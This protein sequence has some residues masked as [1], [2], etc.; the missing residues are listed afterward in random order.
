MQ[1]SVCG[2]WAGVWLWLAC[3][4]GALAQPLDLFAS[5]DPIARAEQELA[6]RPH[7]QDEVWRQLSS[8]GLPLQSADPDSP[9]RV[10]AT[11]LFQAEHD[12]TGVRLDS[13]LNAVE[14]SGRVEDYVRDFALPMS[15]IAQSD[16]W[17]RTVSVPSD[18]TGWSADELVLEARL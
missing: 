1:K 12:V 11:F 2:I 4:A 3:S 14:V 15:R 17:M 5:D 8:R 7:A 13:V 10:L 16:I 6:L 9:D 18:A